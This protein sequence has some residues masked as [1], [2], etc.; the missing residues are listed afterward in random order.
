MGVEKYTS[1][2]CLNNQ[3][4]FQLPQFMLSNLLASIWREKSVIFSVYSAKEHFRLKR[5][6]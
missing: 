2:R 4:I 1:L 3:E 5:K 6:R